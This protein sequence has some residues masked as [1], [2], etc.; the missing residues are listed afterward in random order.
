MY[1]HVSFKAAHNSV[2]RD[3]IPITEQLRNPTS[4]HPYQAG[5]RGLELDIHDAPNMWEWS[6]SHDG[7]YDGAVNAQLGAYF[8]LL[9]DWSEAHRRHDPILVT[10]DIKPLSK[11]KTGFAHA[12][13]QLVARTLGSD[14]LY[15]PPELQGDAPDLVS[16]A[17]R[18]GWPSIDALRGRFILC[19]SG[20]ESVKKAYSS[21]KNRLAF[22]DIRV[23]GSSRRPNVTHGDRVFLNY[24]A[25]QKN[26]ERDARHFAPYDAFVFRLWGVDDARTWQRALHAGVNVLG[27]DR[28]RNHPWATVSGSTD[29]FLPH[30][31]L[32]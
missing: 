4:R 26:W 5:C 8:T 25:N 19:L 32:P 28:V 17:N 30:Q 29:C 14:L 1:S 20:E 27:T 10:I 18:N 13:D 9:R 21:A 2:D 6:V 22:A 11:S 3:E 12:F 24:K 15:T 16:G 23:T 7:P 31:L